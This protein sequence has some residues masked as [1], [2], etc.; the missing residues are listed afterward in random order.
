MKR[1][2]IL[3]WL[4]PF[5]LNAQNSEVGEGDMALDFSFSL[6]KDKQAQLSD[7]RDKHVVIVFFATWCSY[8]IKEL[9][10]VEED[11]WQAYKDNSDVV[12][13]VFGREH[14]WDEVN[15]F[16]EKKQFTMPMYPDPER[17][18]FSKFARQ[19][20]PRTYLISKEGEIVKKQVGFNEESFNVI[21]ETL[22][23]EISN[24]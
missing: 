19:S 14:T 15:A 2:L 17:D 4:F 22:K 6:T 7:F 1:I 9:P 3:L 24:D 8:C 23:A 18:V 12:L 16:K 10:H 20:I 13:L 5:I 21:L 11:I